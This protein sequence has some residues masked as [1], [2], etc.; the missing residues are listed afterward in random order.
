M[1]PFLPSNTTFLLHISIN[2]L[3]KG[4]DDDDDDYDDDDDG[5]DDDDNDDDDDDYDDDYDDNNNSYCYISRTASP[6]ISDTSFYCGDVVFIKYF[7]HG[8]NLCSLKRHKT[9]FFSV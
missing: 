3:H 1:L 2:T 5:G 4:D 8:L 6:V 7:C 9:I